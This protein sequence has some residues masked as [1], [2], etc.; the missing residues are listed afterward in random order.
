MAAPHMD[1]TGVQLRDIESKSLCCTSQR[2]DQCTTRGP[3]PGCGTGNGLAIGP[4]L[5]PDSGTENVR[6]R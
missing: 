1:N 6:K 2:K 4:V 3:G 5:G